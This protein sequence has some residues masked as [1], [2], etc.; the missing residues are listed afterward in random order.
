MNQKRITK[1]LLH[2]GLSLSL[3]GL[4]G[5][6]W[7]DILDLIGPPGIEQTTPSDSTMPL[8]QLQRLSDDSGQDNE[9]TDSRVVSA[10]YQ[11]S[12]PEDYNGGDLLI[13]L[14]IAA[15]HLP[16]DF[17]PF[18]LRPEYFDEATQS[19]VPSGAFPEYDADQRLLYFSD[20]LVAP[21][22]G[23]Q[24]QQLAKP[25]KYRVQSAL[26]SNV[27]TAQREGSH[28]RI[29]YYPSHLG[30]KH[31]IFTDA[32][33]GHQGLSDH[34]EVPD[35]IEDLDAVLNEVYTALLAVSHNKGH[36]F[37]AL[38]VQDVYVQNTGV[39]AGNSDLGGPLYLSNSLIKTV[40]DLKVTAAHELVHVFQGQYYGIQGLWTG[41]Q[42]RSFIEATANYY[43]ATVSS[44]D[45]A[46]K[47][48]FFGDAA[49]AYLSVP[50][51]ENNSN[52]M[53]ASG[54]F[55]DWLSQKYGNTLIGEALRRSGGNDWTALSDA[56]RAAKTGD[57]LGDAY[58]AYLIAIM[59]RP[60]DTAK[61][62]GFVR[63]Q[64][65]QA[66]AS[67][68]T[69][70]NQLNNSKTYFTLSHTLPPL[71]SL[72]AW[73]NFANSDD[74]LLVIDARKTQGTLL[75]SL[76]YTD[77][78]D[79]NADYLNWQPLE[80]HGI[81]SIIGQANTVAH[82]GRDQAQKQ[83]NQ[84]F[85]NGSP[86]SK[87]QVDV[88]YYLLRPPVIS[89]SSDRFVYWR[90]DSLGNIPRDLIK[91]FN[92]YYKDY[93]RRWEL[94]ERNIPVAWGQREQ[95][96]TLKN[97][98]EGH[99]SPP[100]FL[101]TVSDAFG[102]Q[103]PPVIEDQAK[104]IL[105][106]KLLTD[107]HSES[108]LNF[109]GKVEL[110]AEVEGLEDTRLKW[111]VVRQDPST[112]GDSELYCRGPL[113]SLMVNGSKAIYTAP[114]S[115][116][117]HYVR[118]SSVARPD[119]YAQEYM[120]TTGGFCVAPGTDVTLSNGQRQPI[121]TLKRGDVIQGWDENTGQ[122]VTATIEGV[123]THRQPNVLYQVQAL[124]GD[125]LRVTANHPVY[126]REAGWIN[127][128]A[129]KPGMTLLQIDRRD[130]RFRENTVMG[131]VR[132]SSETAVVYNLKTSSGNYFA[133][134]LLVHNKC[135]APGTLID[136]PSGPRAVETLKPGDVVWTQV[137]GQRVLTHITTVYQKDTVLPRL[138]GK[139][140]A[141]GQVVTANHWLQY[142]G[143]WVQAGD[144]NL[145]DTQIV[146]TVYD[147]DTAVGTY[148]AS[149][150]LMGQP[151]PL[152]QTV[153]NPLCFHG[154]NMSNCEG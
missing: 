154:D 10:T 133:N 93:G 77:E 62:H 27:L 121:E 66:A 92:L 90:L 24:T 139:V 51:N 56:I 99:V 96:Y 152:P 31:K 78:S 131:I 36:V 2:L 108:Y 141:P 35:F 115:Y 143:R 20:S 50:L 71:T 100:E 23:F 64:M 132:E 16:A 82:V 84:L 43:A 45:D 109:G 145:P 37:S 128:D 134:D 95:R 59:T 126:T 79:K 83:L 120:T 118:V 130:G 15:Q 67:K 114:G 68:M 148:L 34:A 48:R 33:W 49:S 73:M 113:G 74:A 80:R 69:P 135:L 107:E 119:V 21:G 149:G 136:T 46:A 26:F 57:S 140:L 86:A 40:Q 105:T 117:S 17:K 13:A 103:W 60:E 102:H 151:E 75:K 89:D 122:V 106:S 101:V 76:S 94:I 4:T 5:C 12:P 7:N 88:R 39:A 58:E 32:Q 85:I 8:A 1:P 129:L 3:F 150:V 38:D 72:W 153:I 9:E 70:N 81:Q 61:F 53:Y 30:S 65:A 116:A 124:D 22:A 52:S 55:F 47:A 44:L 110:V 54:H 28:F 112:C 14:P 104:I 125:T 144:T 147:L 123:L 98:V 18:Q 91:G 41:R 25:R 29:H 11:I 146:G 42:N 127:V 19:W 63:G 97:K 142:Q 6:G 111:E 87:A 138:P 137:A